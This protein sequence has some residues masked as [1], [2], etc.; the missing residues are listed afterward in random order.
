MKDHLKL[1]IKDPLNATGNEYL[2]C[3]RTYQYK[4]GPNVFDVTLTKI[5]ET[6][7]Y[8]VF[9]FKRT[10]SQTIFNATTRKNLYVA[11]YGMWRLFSPGTFDLEK[12]KA[13]RKKLIMEFEKEPHQF[14]VLDISDDDEN[15]DPK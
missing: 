9:T 13:Y 8:L 5:T 1:K 14:E 11:Y 15:E 3:G 10:G 2:E 4:E 12:V 6:S 7:N